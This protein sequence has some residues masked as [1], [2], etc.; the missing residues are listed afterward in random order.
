MRARIIYRRRGGRKMRTK[1]KE[2]KRKPGENAKPIP[3]EQ[4]MDAVIDTDEK[5]RRQ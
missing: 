4:R 5:Q 1:R 3:S 2:Q